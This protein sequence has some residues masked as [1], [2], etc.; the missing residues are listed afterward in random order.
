MVSIFHVKHIVQRL[1]LISAPTFAN[2]GV[3]TSTLLLVPSCVIVS[4]F[5]FLV[6]R[7]EVFLPIFLLSTSIGIN[8]VNLLACCFEAYCTFFAF[9]VFEWPGTFIFVCY[10]SLLVQL[11]AV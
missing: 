6:R 5:T 2:V 10:F 9:V 8:A 7:P 1:V 4:A 3:T 11:A